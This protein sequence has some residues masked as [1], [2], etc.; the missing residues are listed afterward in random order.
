[1]TSSLRWLTISTLR[2]RHSAK[3]DSFFAFFWLGH[4]QNLRV[5]TLFRSVAAGFLVLHAIIHAYTADLPA[6]QFSGVLSYA[7]IYMAALAGAAYLFSVRGAG[8][9]AAPG[10]NH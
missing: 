9:S 6:N 1:M 3:R 2:Q 10:D 5:Q 4:H 8:A 7:L